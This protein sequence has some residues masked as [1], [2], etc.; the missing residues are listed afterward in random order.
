MNAELKAYIDRRTNVLA[1]VRNVLI[2]KLN[3]AKEPLHID[4][5][6][7]LFG[8]GLALDSVDAVE[9]IIS[10][11]TEFDILFPEDTNIDDTLSLYFM[12]KPFFIF[13]I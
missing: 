13:F 2:E 11:E 9:L 6:A 10:V 8:T 12:F 7:P 3:V 1:R 4:P 5:N